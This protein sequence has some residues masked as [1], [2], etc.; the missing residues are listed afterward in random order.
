MKNLSSENFEIIGKPIDNTDST[1]P[2]NIKH[3]DLPEQLKTNPYD[4]QREGIDF[5]CSSNRQMLL[6][7]AGTGKTLMSIGAVLIRKEMGKIKHTLVITGRCSL[8]WNW[9][10]EIKTHTGIKATVLGS[11]KNK[12]GQ[13]NVKSN[14]DKLEDL[15]SITDDQ[16]FLLTNIQSLQNKDVANKLKQLIS[17]NIIQCIIFDECH[18]VRNPSSIQAKAL[19]R[20][21]PKYIS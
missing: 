7:E 20:L 15:N 13:W 5:V 19:L 1:K 14:A 8:I 18:C 21:T 3:F 10:D 11:R 6:D 4:Y 12:K 9:Y 2:K 16:L 17:K